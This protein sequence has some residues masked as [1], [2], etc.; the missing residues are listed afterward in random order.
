MR[1]KAHLASKTLVAMIMGHRAGEKW[2]QLLDDMPEAAGVIDLEGKIRNISRIAGM[3]IPMISGLLD[4]LAAATGR[5]PEELL[6]RMRERLIK[7]EL[8]GF[9]DEQLEG[10][11]T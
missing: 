8:E 9:D 2:L 3:A 11:D 1:P 10:M 6:M 7:I 4:Q 5:D